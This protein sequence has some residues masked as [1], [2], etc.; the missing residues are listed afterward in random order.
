MLRWFTRSPRTPQSRQARP[1]LEALEA[2]DCPAA[3]VIS[4][5]NIVYGT[6]RT[7][8]IQ[9]TVQDDHPDTCAIALGGVVS[10]TAPVA[11][12]GTFSVTT[13]ATGLGTATATVTDDQQL[14]AEA[15]ALVESKAPDITNFRVVQGQ[16]GLWI[17][18]GQV[19]DESPTTARVQLAGC[20]AFQNAAVTVNADGTFSVVVNVPAGQ[21]VLATALATDCWGLESD[22]VAAPVTT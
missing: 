5:L 9:G 16:G 21:N 15:T 18:S 11:V 20:Q 7:V 10:G 17:F 4:Q 6:G 13:Q 14:T 1:W 12:D 8:T 3:P 2:R 19:V 22:Q